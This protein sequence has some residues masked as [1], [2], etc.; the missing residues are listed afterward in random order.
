MASDNPLIIEDNFINIPIPGLGDCFYETLRLYGKLYNVPQ[1]NQTVL[2]LRKY[3]HSEIMKKSNT[4]EQFQIVLSGFESKNLAII[5]KK[6]QFL[7]EA[8]IAAV[9]LAYRIFNINLVFYN[10][11]ANG[12][13]IDRYPENTDPQL[14][15]LH[16]IRK[17]DIHFELLI[18]IGDP[19]QVY[20][21]AERIRDGR[22]KVIE[23]EEE[24]DR[25]IARIIA[26]ELKRTQKSVREEF[27]SIIEEVLEEQEDAE[28][29]AS[30]VMIYP[31]NQQ[32]AHEA[33]M[34]VLRIFDENHIANLTNSFQ[35]LH[36]GPVV[37]AVSNKALVMKKEQEE[38]NAALAASFEDVN[39][40][41][42]YAAKLA[43]EISNA[44]YVASL[45]EEEPKPKKK[46]GPKLPPK[47]GGTRKRREHM[48]KTKKLK[49][50]SV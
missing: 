34:R 47:K 16:I 1:L 50:R 37:A 29:Q 31:E 20:G 39:S 5:K 32:A 3:V 25:L 30:K 36:V 19:I 42:L 8:N 13:R 26:K 45:A 4:N 12:L 15:T 41:A 6:E 21:Y 38:L 11:D 44:A 14:H 17:N 9:Q 27:N 35:Q 46:K 48:R 22:L 23:L 49:K 43:Q 7:N 2:Q 24:R 40:N 28:E 18:P 33:S 10:V